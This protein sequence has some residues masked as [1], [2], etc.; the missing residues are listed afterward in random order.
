MKKTAKALAKVD[1]ASS[2]AP[3]QAAERSIASGLE[4][5]AG[6]VASM[7]DEQQGEAL[8]V[9][10]SLSD[11]LEATVDFVKTRVKAYVLEHGATTTAK[12][13]RVATA[14]EWRL[15]IRPQ[16]TGVDPKKLEALARAKGL[17]VGRV[18]DPVVSYQVNETK[19][20]AALVG[21]QLTP[22][23]VE[24]CRYQLSYAVLAPEKVQK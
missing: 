16:R 3:F 6:A 15:E 10:R 21:G 7:R 20:Q 12:G 9:C 11:A 1:A 8:T 24:S 19:L 18:M 5:L 4:Q 23:E 14:G 22:A 13:S 2:I 17:D